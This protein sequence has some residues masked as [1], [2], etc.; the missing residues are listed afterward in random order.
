MDVSIGP[1]ENMDKLRILLVENDPDVLE[2]TTSLL[3][4]LGY[5][6][7]PA[8]GSNEA[9][10][11]IT[12][13]TDAFDAVIT[14]YSLEIINGI[15]LAAMIKDVSEDVP[16][17]LYSGKIDLID[18]IQMAEACIAGII[19]KPCEVKKMDS[20]IKEIINQKVRV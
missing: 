6:V 1:S 8:T 9:I 18:K 19:K 14:D 16:T 15:E 2:V 17:I 20:I 3:E 4:Y 7:T 13:D 5:L 11:K 12:E 10:T